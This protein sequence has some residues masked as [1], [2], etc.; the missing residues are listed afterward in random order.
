MPVG[1]A[2]GGG[3]GRPAETKALARLRARPCVGTLS[4]WWC[5]HGCAEGVA[6]L[7]RAL[8]PTGGNNGLEPWLGGGFHIV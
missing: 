2:L 1:G 8:L 6:M 5:L 7:G 4:V 3:S